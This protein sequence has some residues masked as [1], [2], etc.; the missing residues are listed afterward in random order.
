MS[1]EKVT[2]EEFRNHPLVHKFAEMPDDIYSNFAISNPTMKIAVDTV[3]QVLKMSQ[4]TQ[5]EMKD[6]DETVS[7]KNRNS[8]EE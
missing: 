4:K 6:G 3:R 8:N 5:K 2:L 1:S 7:R